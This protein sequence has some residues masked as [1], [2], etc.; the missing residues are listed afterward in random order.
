MSYL[1]NKSLC[2][3]IIKSKASFG[4]SNHTALPDCQCFACNGATK[5]LYLFH[6]H[7]YQIIVVVQGDYSGTYFIHIDLKGDFNKT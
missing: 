5:I 6:S 2:K 4:A 3:S 1:Y 7:I